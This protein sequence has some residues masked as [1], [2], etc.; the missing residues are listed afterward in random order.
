MRAYDLIQKKRDGGELAPEELDALIAG[1]LR[2]EVA[3]Y[4]MS[5]FLMAVYLRGMTARETAAL[6]MAM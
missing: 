1:Y 2:D 5:A 3:D 4:Q 6:T